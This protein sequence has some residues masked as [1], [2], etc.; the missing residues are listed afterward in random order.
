MK[1][2]LSENYSISITGK[3]LNYCIFAPINVYLILLNFICVIV[4]LEY[5]NN[6]FI[7]RDKGLY[8]IKL[9]FYILNYLYTNF[10]IYEF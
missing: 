1:F 7:F 2:G 5:N 3:I 9:Y 8:E 10:I 6:T 4:L